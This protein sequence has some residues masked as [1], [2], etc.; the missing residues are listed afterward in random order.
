MG[1]TGPHGLLPAVHRVVQ[2]VPH[3]LGEGVQH[4]HLHPAPA[5]G[6]PAAQERG[7]HPE[8]AYMAAA[9]SAAGIP[10]LTGRS[11]VPVTDTSPASHCTSMS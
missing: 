5:P 2:R 3:P 1:E 7:E 9:M 11:G 8:N 6:D 10:A 4:R